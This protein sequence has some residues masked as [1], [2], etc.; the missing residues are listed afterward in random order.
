MEQK[1]LTKG[2]LLQHQKDSVGELPVLDQ[3]VEVVQQLEALGPG[4]FVADGVEES[5]SGE[6]GDQ[7]LDKED[8]ERSR[9]DSQQKVVENEQRLE[10]KCILILHDLATTKDDDEVGDGPHGDLGLGRKWSD[11]LLEDE[12]VD[13]F[14]CGEFIGLSKIGVELDAKG[15]IDAEVNLVQECGHGG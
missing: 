4:A 3:I 10:L 14:S 2:L 5:V 11:T 12:R 7:V 1:G 15:L 8:Q 9:G 6:D 13:G